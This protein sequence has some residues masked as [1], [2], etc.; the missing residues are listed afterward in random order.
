MDESSGRNKIGKGSD[1][2]SMIPG[3][4]GYK[5]FGFPNSIITKLRYCITGTLTSTA[6][7]SSYQVF[8][9]NG[10]Y[11]PD[12]TGAGHQPLY[13]DQYALLYNKYVV[14]GSK[15]TIELSNGT[16]S[17][18][19]CT[20]VGDD[21]STISTTPFTRMEQNNSTF[22]VLPPIGGGTRIL[23]GTYEPLAQLGVAAKD[24]G[25]SATAFGSNPTEGWHYALVVNTMDSAS[26][27]MYYTCEIEYT[28]KFSELLT[29]TQS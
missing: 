27:T 17:P 21:D 26:Q 11:D 23:V 19:L 20:L 5:I 4:D 29:P 1:E 8:S 7:S 12:T 9:A 6:G 24:D 25:A 15:I 3:V 22:S 18:F 16:T 2:A 13:Y 14:L 28:V 10:I